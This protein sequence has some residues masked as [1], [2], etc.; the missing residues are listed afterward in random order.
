LDETVSRKATT[1]VRDLP[2]SDAGGTRTVVVGDR[3]TQRP[4]PTASMIANRRAA[5]LVRTVR[6]G[7]RG[8]VDRA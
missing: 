1:Q 3:P 7:Q 6:W 8:S 4:Q 2:F 5:D